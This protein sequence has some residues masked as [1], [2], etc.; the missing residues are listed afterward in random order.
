MLRQ[1]SW[2]SFRSPTVAKQTLLALM[3][4]K[5]SRITKQNKH[6]YCLAKRNGLA[7][8]LASFRHA[9]NARDRAM[10]KNAIARWYV[11]IL[12]TFLG[13]ARETPV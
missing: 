6:V 8:V 13:L 3:L 2:Q 11:C 9:R 4:T 7:S 10:I 5:T 1:T 12:A